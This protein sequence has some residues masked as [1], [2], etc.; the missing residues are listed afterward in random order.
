MENKEKYF[1][2]PLFLM[3]GLFIDKEK[4]LNDIIS[5]GIYH[6][7]KMDYDIEEVAKQLMYGYYRSG[8]TND[9]IVL[10]QSYIDKESIEIDE[11][12]NSFYGS[13]FN[14]E[15]EVYQLLEIFENDN[16]FK[17]KA[18][19]F[20]QIKQAY[21][22]LGIEGSVENT[23]KAGKAIEKIIPEKEPFPNISKSLVFDFRDN[24]KSEFDLIQFAAYISI[25]SILGRKG[26][27]K[28]NK[29][30][31]ISRMFGYKS[32]KDLPD[33]MDPAIK[34]LFIKYS[35]RYHID[36]VLLHLELNWNII[37]YSRNI[38]GLYVGN[39]NKVSIADLVLFAETKKKKRKIENLKSAK[40]EARE[41]ALQQLNKEPHLNKQNNYEKSTI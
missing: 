40:I 24:E 14:P 22:F 13:E 15:T 17:E 39:G 18:I 1:Q 3:R 34:D 41:K 4:A 25:R 30:M 29:K 33:E 10:T 31:I 16:N 2:F 37:T 7:S 12:N 8:L 9:L 21:S 28:T 23:L 11:D 35:N 20:F 6:F 26:Y 19:E 38:R 5:Y 27:C 36:K 32:N